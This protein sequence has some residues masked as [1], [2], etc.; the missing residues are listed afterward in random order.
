VIQ[1]EGILRQDLSTSS[2]R[3]AQDKWGM[4]HRRQFE[5]GISNFEF[6]NPQSAIRNPKLTHCLEFEGLP[7]GLNPSSYGMVY[8]C[9]GNPYG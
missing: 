3:V 4:A 6:L 8:W 5:F 1:V 7:T 2:G 9:A